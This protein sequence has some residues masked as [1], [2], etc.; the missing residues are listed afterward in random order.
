[1]GEQYHRSL[2]IMILVL[3]IISVLALSFIMVVYVTGWKKI[4]SFPMRL[5][6]IINSYAGILLMSSLL[7]S[8]PVRVHDGTL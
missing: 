1:M 4:N 5:V 8:K 3:N 2:A 7:R 6:P